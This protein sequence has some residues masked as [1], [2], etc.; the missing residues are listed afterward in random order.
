MNSINGNIDGIF[1]FGEGTIPLAA[2]VNEKN[3]LSSLRNTNQ[4]P[5][6]GPKK[7]INVVSACKAVFP[8]AIIHRQPNIPE[9]CQP[10]A[11]SIIITGRAAPACHFQ[12]RIFAKR[13]AG[14]ACNLSALPLFPE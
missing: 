14:C 2:K 1:K 6:F 12:T 13:Q 7:V 4:K 11:R 9:E 10:L 8:A 3:L 5:V